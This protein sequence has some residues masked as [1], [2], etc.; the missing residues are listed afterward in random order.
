[1]A[2]QNAAVRRELKM[3]RLLIAYILTGLFFL[4]LPGTFLGVWNLISIS[5]RH[6]LDS[7]S[8]AFLQAHGH[9]QIFGW[10]GT[11]ILGIGFYSL[12]KMGNLPAFAMERGWYCYGLWTA[13]IMLRWFAGI[14]EW[15]WR[16]L[17]PLSA[18]FE[19]AAFLLFFRTVSGH[20]AKTPAATGAS[21]SRKREPW[22]WLVMASTLGFLVT[23]ALNLGAAIQASTGGMGPALGHVSDQRL[24]TVATWGF[25]VPAVWGFNARWLPVFLG[26]DQPRTRFLFLA[27]ACAW[28]GVLGEFA[29]RLVLSGA[30]LTIAAVSAVFA[31]RIAEPSP[32]PARLLG[33]H[34]SFPFFVRLAYAW[35]AAAAVLSVYASRLDVSG[36]I[37]GASR[38]ALTVGFLSTM[39]FAIGQRVLPAFCGARVL[40]NSRLMLA[41]LAALN[42]GC[43][44]RVAAEI[45][46]Y[47]AD[48]Q[49]SWHLLPYSA[50]IELMA[51]GLFATNLAL[52]L[53][54]PP[55]HL[56][57]AAA[58]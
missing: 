16:V 29:G 12:T 15:Q 45:P 50:M 46:A 10:V 6:A 41:S 1:M 37:W 23:L 17:L 51:V 48:V 42:F 39:V 13:G 33:V 58:I 24:V 8:P 20:R 44:L 49:L 4:L 36:G 27:L 21:P 30:L 2:G 53:L 9:A 3:Q 52:T 43:L 26:L 34:P 14:V 38:H 31:L 47:E 7:L 25:L 57:P 32:R 35:L 5:S 55:A 56:R 22:M 40:Y 18:L 28:A 19:L 54:Q 11:F